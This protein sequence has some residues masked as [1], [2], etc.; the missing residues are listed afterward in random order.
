M[1]SQALPAQAE[2]LFRHLFEQASLGVA[3]E[4]LEGRLFGTS[5]S[6]GAMCSSNSKSR[7][8]P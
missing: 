5:T 6:S 4:D 3:V 7:S 2:Q 8:W 1:P